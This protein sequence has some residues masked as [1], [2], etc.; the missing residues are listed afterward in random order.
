M[1]IEQKLYLWLGVMDLITITIGSWKSYAQSKSVKC[2]EQTVP[3]S[4]VRNGRGTIPV[5]RVV[6]VYV[7]EGTWVLIP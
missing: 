3:L 7:T 2:H 1:G 4:I 6:L 5:G